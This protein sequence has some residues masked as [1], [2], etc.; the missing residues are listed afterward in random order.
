MNETS[1]IPNPWIYRAAVLTTALAILPI[2]LGAMTTTAN[3]GMAFPNWPNSDEYTMFSYPWLGLIQDMGTNKEN[4]DKFLEHGHRLAGVVIGIA[5][6]VL[7]GLCWTK[8]TTSTLT[9]LGTGVLL[10]VIGQ[11]MIGG[12]RVLERMPELAMLHGLFASIVFAL[13]ATT[14]TVA[15]SRWSSQEAMMSANSVKGAKIASTFL[16]IYLLVQYAL[17]GII[18]HPMTGMRAPIHEHLG[19]G[20]LSIVVV[21]LVAFFEFRSN[22]SWLKRGMGMV[23]GLI[24]LQV[25]IGLI[26]YAMKF[27]VPSMGIVAVAESAGQVISRTAHMITGVLVI[28]ATAVLTIRTYRVDYVKNYSELAVLSQSID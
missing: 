18:R 2:L 8:R 13:M 14:A 27:G 5:A 26:T 25:L 19:L 24:V 21:G 20:I 16:L 17:G 28:G 3:A 11:G 9:W 12:F 15:S 22:S 1:H 6:I 4:Y 7:A 23:L 10:A